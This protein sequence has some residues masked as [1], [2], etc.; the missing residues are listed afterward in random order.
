MGASA[1]QTGLLAVPA[2]PEVSALWASIPCARC[3]Q[4][5]VRA[6][7]EGEPLCENHKLEWLAEE[8]APNGR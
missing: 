6:V 1:A 3:G 7:V 2:E 5:P 4:H 8:V